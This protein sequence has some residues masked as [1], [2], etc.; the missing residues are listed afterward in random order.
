MNGRRIP[1][2]MHVVWWAMVKAER[3]AQWARLL[4]VRWHDNHGAILPGETTPTPTERK[5]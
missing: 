5:P 2:R 4:W 1:W 3:F